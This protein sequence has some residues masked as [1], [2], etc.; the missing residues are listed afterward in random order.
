[1]SINPAS[2]RY[3]RIRQIVSIFIPLPVRVAVPRHVSR[4]VHFERHLDFRTII[5]DLLPA[6]WR[7]PNLR[8]QEF[9]R[10]AG[11]IPHRFLM[12]PVLAGKD[13]RLCP[14]GSLGSGPMTDPLRKPDVFRF[15]VRSTSLILQNVDDRTDPT[16]RETTVPTVSRSR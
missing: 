3:E 5:P 13:Q 4:S 1:M 7:T 10:T 8:A 12:I 16:E 6:L 15:R 14:V 2:P 9:A 11:M